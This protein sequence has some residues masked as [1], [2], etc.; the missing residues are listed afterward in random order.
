ML[1]LTLFSRAQKAGLIE[2]EMKDQFDSLYS[3]EALLDRVV[4][5]IGSDKDGSPFNNEWGKAL[6]DS[7]QPHPAFELIRFLP[8]ADLRGAPFFMKRFVK[9][10]FP[11][12][13][14]RWVLMDW[15]GNFAKTYR[16]SAKMSNIIIFDRNGELIYQTA[17][18]ELHPETL[19]AML[20]MLR[21]V[22]E[23]QDWTKTLRKKASTNP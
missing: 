20:Q 4:I 22:L 6:H 2:F 21:K 19:A 18:R 9:S 8:V 13:K 11:K 23:E 16:F 7:L 12:E 10:H 17:V 5:L 15:G 1:S 14:E 3:H